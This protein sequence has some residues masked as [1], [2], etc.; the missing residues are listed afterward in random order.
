M[1]LTETN[2]IL[3]VVLI[4]LLIC[5]WVLKPKVQEQ[6]KRTEKQMRVERRYFV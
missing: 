2:L 3:L 6:I 5:G 1:K 4:A